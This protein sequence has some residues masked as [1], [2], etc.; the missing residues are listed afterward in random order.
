MVTF[1]NNTV[2]NLEEVVDLYSDHLLNRFPSLIQPGEKEPDP[3]G[4]IGNEETLTAA[5]KS[6]L[7]AFLKRL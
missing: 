1:R 7:V 3:D 4:D 5:Q 6:D 2:E